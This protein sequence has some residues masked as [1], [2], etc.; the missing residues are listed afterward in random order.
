[1]KNGMTDDKTILTCA[2]TDVQRLD[3]MR[4]TG[5]HTEFECSGIGIVRSGR[6]DSFH[7][8]GGEPANGNGDSIEALAACARRAGR[9]TA[10]P[11]ETRQRL[12]L[13]PLGVFA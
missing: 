5:A 12:G 4:K 13:K 2:L 10:S 7:L 3:V 6:E 9:E 8:P 1:M 11:A